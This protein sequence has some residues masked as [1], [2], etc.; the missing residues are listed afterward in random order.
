MRKR[1][2][3]KFLIMSLIIVMVIAVVGC[4]KTVNKGD[5]QTKSGQSSSTGNAKIDG[6]YKD[7]ASLQGNEALKFFEG[8]KDKGLTDAEIL[9]FFIDLPL[10]QANKQIAQIYKDQSFEMYSK[11]YPKGETFK[12]FQW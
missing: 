7:V 10:S 6:L 3:S 1:I 9:Q 2:L 8:L 11:S 4:G 5:S 12:G